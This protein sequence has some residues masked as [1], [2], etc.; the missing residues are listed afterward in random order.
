MPPETPAQ[1]GPRDPLF[2]TITEAHWAE[3]FRKAKLTRNSLSLQIAE[4]V[5]KES[6]G[7][8]YVGMSDHRKLAANNAALEVDKLILG[9]GTP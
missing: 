8:Y 9:K 5:L 4:V 6:A 3:A 1:P 2:P 7:L